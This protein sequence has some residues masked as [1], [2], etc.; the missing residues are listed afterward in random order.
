MTMMPRHRQLPDSQRGF[1]LLEV[2][3][4]LMVLTVGLLALAAM[5]EFAVTRSLDA[6][7]LSIA[8]NLAAEMIERIEYNPKNVASYNGIN[9]S[10]SNNICPATPVMANGDCTQWRNR[11]LATR[12]PSPA[13]TVSVTTTGPASLNQWL[14]TVTIRWSG[15]VVPMTFSTVVSI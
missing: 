11:M 13:G 5:Q 15:L 8:T 9:V 2:M 10:S 1:S 14:V 6:N 3:I 7:E 4:A 12:L